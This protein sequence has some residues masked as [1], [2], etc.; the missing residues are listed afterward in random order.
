MFTERK[1][2][3]PKPIFKEKTQIK[4]EEP[5]LKTNR[6]SHSLSKQKLNQMTQNRILRK[7]RSQEYM[8]AVHKLDAGGH[9]HNQY[10]VNAIINVLNNE[11]PELDLA[12]V[13]LGI[14]SKCYLGEPYEVHSLDITGGII[15]H[16]VRGQGMPG[17]LEAARGIAEH[18]GYDFIEVYS[19]CYR[20]VA[21]NGTVAVIKL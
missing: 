6:E 7:K 18:G 13:L 12:G 2:S 20:A 16:Y 1:K 19:D 3:M 9:I 10:K 11:F 14:V 5:K 17:L 15:E 21:P 8:D 4:T